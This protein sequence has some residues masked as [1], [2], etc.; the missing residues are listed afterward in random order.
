M[1]VFSSA[2]FSGCGM[3][4]V[5][6]IATLGTKGISELTTNA[7]IAVG[8]FVEAPAMT[9]FIVRHLIRKEKTA[10]TPHSWRAF[11][12]TPKHSSTLQ[13]DSGHLSGRPICD[14]NI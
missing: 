14:Q 9:A 1:R 11:S 8:W 13:N 10:W 3:M 7:A 5:S 12:V 6:G 2:R 4:A